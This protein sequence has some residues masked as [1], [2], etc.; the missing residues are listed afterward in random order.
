MLDN[1]IFCDLFQLKKCICQSKLF[2]YNH[3]TS[4]YYFG[5]KILAFK[6]I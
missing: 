6:V 2:I 3:N 4:N 5:E 1:N